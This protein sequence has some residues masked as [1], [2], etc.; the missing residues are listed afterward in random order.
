MEFKHRLESRFPGITKGFVSFTLSLVVCLVLFSNRAELCIE[1]LKAF[2]GWLLIVAVIG[3]ALPSRTVPFFLLLL[4]FLIAVP[5]LA[6]FSDESKESFRLLTQ[7]LIVWFPVLLFLY[8]RSVIQYWKRAALFVLTFGILLL[9]LWV[10]GPWILSK[11]LV[12]DWNTDIDRRPVPK[13]G[14]TVLGVNSDGLFF[15]EPSNKFTKAGTNILFLGDSFTAGYYPAK[16]GEVAVLENSFPRLVERKL[17]MLHPDKE[18]RV[19]NFGWASSS[20]VLQ[21]RR[22]AE[23]AAAYKPDI[24]IQCFDM[25][26]FREDLVYTKQLL[27]S[28]QIDLDKIDLFSAMEIAF[29]RALYGVPN[30]R[31]WVAEQLPVWMA[32]NKYPIPENRFFVMSQHL[33]NS[34][35]YLETTWNTILETRDLSATL[36]AKYL[37]IILPRYQQFNPQEC[38]GDW[39]VGDF[40]KTDEY[41]LEPF[42]FFEAKSKTVTFPIHS[43]LAPFK[44]SKE[45]P[46]CYPE[47][48]HWNNKGHQVAAD[49][50]TDIIEKMSLL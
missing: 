6:F 27:R 24:I 35:P 5:S 48:P 33:I 30:F 15:T 14:E 21:L 23:I 26:D 39:E 17:S 32:G 49:A 42:R 38:P 46:L 9:L 10:T 11:I 19:A 34:L 25:T 41:Y 2:G 16:D 40:P 31:R 18:I 12:P 45:Y 36:G 43:L 28:G 7:F 8:F 29:S 4:G 3:F 37:L 44:N 13:K 50:I 22:L 47:D 1:V 20:P